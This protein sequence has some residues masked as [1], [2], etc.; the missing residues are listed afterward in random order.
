MG[1]DG[2]ESMSE[3]TR[4]RCVS[5]FEWRAGKRTGFG[6]GCSGEGKEVEVEVED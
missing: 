2:L 5:I 3:H 1:V 6:D 4:D